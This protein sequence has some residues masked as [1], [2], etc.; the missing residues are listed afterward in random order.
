MHLRKIRLKS[1]FPQAP[2]FFHELSDLRMRCGHEIYAGVERIL[3][4]T[5]VGIRWKF[6]FHFR[7]T[8]SLTWNGGKVLYNKT[9]ANET[10]ILFFALIMAVLKGLLG[11]QDEHGDLCGLF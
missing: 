6:P 10:L 3:F 5:K 9:K 11:F 8:W 4:R 7:R 1:W 2:V